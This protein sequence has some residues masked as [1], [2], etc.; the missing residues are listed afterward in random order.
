MEIWAGERLKQGDVIKSMLV[1]GVGGVNE[2][3]G[4]NW[5]TDTHYYI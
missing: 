5:Y 2:K 4:I 3:T 1:G